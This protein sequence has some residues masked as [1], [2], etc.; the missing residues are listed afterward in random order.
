MSPSFFVTPDQNPCSD[1]LSVSSDSFVSNSNSTRYSISI[2]SRGSISC[3]TIQLLPTSIDTRIRSLIPPSLDSNQS[4]RL[5]TLLTRFVSTFDTSKHNIANTSIN[6]VI[7]TVP[8]SPPA[9]RFYP[10]PDKEDAMYQLMQEFLQAGLISES[11]SPYA[12]PAILIK[13][14]DNSY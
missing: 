14:K 13:K 1:T 8:H 9:C 7:N 12:A 2:D 3:N 11:H 4:D 6:H 10:Q 5:Y